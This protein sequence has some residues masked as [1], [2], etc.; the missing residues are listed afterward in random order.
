MTNNIN[1]NPGFNHAVG[2]KLVDGERSISASQFAKWSPL[3]TTGQV[4]GQVGFPL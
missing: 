4:L 2:D 3:S 1:A